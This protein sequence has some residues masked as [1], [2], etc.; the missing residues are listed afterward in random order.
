MKKGWKATQALLD[1]FFL[2]FKTEY[3][4]TL[5]KRQTTSST[6]APKVGDIVLLKDDQLPRESWKL[7]TVHEITNDDKDHGR[8]FIVRDASNKYYDRN[9]RS[10]IRLE[11]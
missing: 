9:I 4:Q 7:C 5:G 2:R 10:V 3:L 11:M 6:D 8:R 1:D